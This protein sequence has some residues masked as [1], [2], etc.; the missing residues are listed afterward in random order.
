V[1]TLEELPRGA[2]L[3]IKANHRWSVESKRKRSFLRRAVVTGYVLGDGAEVVAAD[4]QGNTST[5]YL[6]RRL[7]V[8]LVSDGVWAPSGPVPAKEGH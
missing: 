5:V 2:Q 8:H 6:Y 4:S 1:K 7:A 3:A